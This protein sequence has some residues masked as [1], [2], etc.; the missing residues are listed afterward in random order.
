MR[1]QTWYE[2]AFSVEDGPSKPRTR[3]MEDL[4]RAPA[5]ALALEEGPSRQHYWTKPRPW[6]QFRFRAMRDTRTHGGLVFQNG[7]ERCIPGPWRRRRWVPRLLIE[8]LSGTHRS[9]LLEGK[10]KPAF[11]IP[12]I[13][14]YFMD[15]EY[16]LSVIAD[17]P[18]KSFAYR[19]LKYL[20]SKFTMYSL[21]NEFQEMAD[22][23][24]CSTLLSEF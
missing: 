18:T 9:A 2:L 3:E 11:D 1:S 13:R 10:D 19:R 8:L 21:L 14:E 5:S 20:S 16:V 12:D 22:M 7:C 6:R 17:G 15:L 23:K 24:V 4:S